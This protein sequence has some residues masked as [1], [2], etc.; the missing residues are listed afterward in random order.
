M[1][2]LQTE[3]PEHPSADG[4]GP[5]K[6]GMAV[7]GWLILCFAIVPLSMAAHGDG[8][9]YTD[10]GLGMLG[11]GIVLVVIHRLTS[12]PRVR[13]PGTTGSA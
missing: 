12:G 11:I 9:V 2:T 3:R 4:R 8:R 1:T 7:I 10:V 13:K 6:P 5:T